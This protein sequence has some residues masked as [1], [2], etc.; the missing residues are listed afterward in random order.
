VSATRLFP[1]TPEQ[2]YRL[3]M[4]ISEEGFWH[5]QLD[6]EVTGRH[7]QGSF[8][9]FAEGEHSDVRGQ[10][11]NLAEGGQLSIPHDRWPQHLF[12]VMGIAGSLDAEIGGR[13][14]P[15]RA[16]TQL[17][18]LPGVPCRLT[19]RSNASLEV[20]SLRSHRPPG[21]LG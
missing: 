21:I 14:L 9:V 18:V 4:V 2:R 13:T 7:D 20:I 11:Y 17:V 19:A 15:L 3:P 16:L 10:V 8:H 5:A 6:D 1:P 12:V